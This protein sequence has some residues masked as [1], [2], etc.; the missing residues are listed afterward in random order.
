[1]AAGQRRSETLM[2]SEFR[3]SLSKAQRQVTWTAAILI[4]AGA[5]MGPVTATAEGES[6][7]LFEYG[8]KVF[9]L[10]QL[11]PKLR[12]LWFSMEMEHL[13]QRRVLLDEILYDVY[14]GQEAA[15]R[16]V[17]RKALANELLRLEPPTDAE[18][19]G[20]YESNKARI[21]E[22]LEQV[23]ERIIKFLQRQEMERA[24]ASL[25]REAKAQG[26]F[27]DLLPIPAS[28]PVS[29]DIG[30]RP[31]KG[32]L[33]AP[34]TIIE[35]A[36]YQCP[37]CQR[38]AAVMDRLLDRFPE[39]IRVVFMDFPV[40]RS[41]VSRTIAEGAACA[42]EQD[43]FWEFHDLAFAR[44]KQLRHESAKE[45]AAELSLDMDAFNAC[46]RSQAATEYVN[47]AARQGRGIGVT[48]TPSVYVDGKPLQ[49]THLERDLR[50]IIE[51][52]ISARKKP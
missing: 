44:Q 22:P 8:G 50:R 45:I 41:G 12:G 6:Q 24:K 43:R 29:I 2:G 14:V 5:L 11:S 3:D 15:R 32:R 26:K 36:D 10:D 38:A 47:A 9:R 17:T 1:M 7:A 40:N 34:I 28:P 49:S 4:M 23:R 31:I 21:G 19:E 42:R 46:R 30:D 35:F 27:R 20:F 48:R 37:H 39:D 52:K 18:V 16:G 33:N 51:N 13:G 25:V